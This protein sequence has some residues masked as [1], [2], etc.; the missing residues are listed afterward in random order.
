MRTTQPMPRSGSTWR[1]VSGPIHKTCAPP[2]PPMASW[3][4]RNRTASSLRDLCRAAVFHGLGLSRRFRGTPQN[5]SESFLGSMSRSLV[6]T[7]Q[8]H[9]PA[10]Q[11][12]FVL[13]VHRQNGCT[14]SRFV[15]RPGT[16]QGTFATNVTMSDSSGASCKGSLPP[17]SG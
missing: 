3:N 10:W 9:Q 7:L 15:R 4:S 1:T 12:L 14:S 16:I 13:H 5:A 8:R 2:K 11:V 6:A 17:Q